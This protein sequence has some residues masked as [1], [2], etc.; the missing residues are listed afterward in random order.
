MWLATTLLVSTAFSTSV[1]PDQYRVRLDDEAQRLHVAACFSG[2][3]PARVSSGRWDAGR[4]LR[5]AEIGGRSVRPRGR[6]LHLPGETA[7]RCLRYAVDLRSVSEASGRRTAS[8]TGLDGTLLSAQAFLWRAP[9]PIEVAFDL[10][11]GYDVSAPWER[12]AEPATFSVPQPLRDWPNRVAIGKFD[13]ET[14]A[15]GDS[16]LRL[17]VMRRQDGSAVDRASIR[18]WIR[19]NA[20]AVA[21]VHGTLP[22]DQ[23]QVLVVP[24]GRGDAVPWAQVL[25]GGGTAVHF[26]VNE[27]RPHAEFMEDWTAAHEFSHTLHPYLSGHGRWVSEGLASYY[28]NVARARAGMLSESQAWQKLEAGFERG[29]NAATQTPLEAA[30]RSGKERRN[31]MRLYWSGAALALLADVELRQQT[32]GRWSLDRA[33]EA[34]ARCCLPAEESWTAGR[35]MRRLDALSGSN[36]FTTTYRRIA[37]RKGFPSVADAYEALGIS[38]RDGRPTLTD[39]DAH[40]ALRAQIMGGDSG[41]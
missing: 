41:V 1:S 4:H 40:R 21:E 3:V 38:I 14:L 6:H 20:S 22:P 29:R 36:V 23:L 12:T 24:I 35:F 39:T 16:S 8:L 17:A 19:T 7:E 28:Q 27:N 15:V 33:L 30:I 37:D 9:R 32:N 13:V 34:F 31:Y 18:E 25:R 2:D 11:D 26:F 10:P 5:D